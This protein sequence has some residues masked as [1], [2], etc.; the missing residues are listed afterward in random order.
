MTLQHTIEDSNCF[1]ADKIRMIFDGGYGYYWIFPR[2]PEKKEVN[3]GFGTFGIYDY[4]L[5]ELLEEFKKKNNIQ[6]KV[7][8]V[9]GGLLPL[10][11]QRPFK[12]KNILFVGD[13]GVGTFPFSGQ[14]IYRALLSGDIA[15][16]CIAKGITKKYPYMINQ[17]FIKWQVFGK[18]FYH[19]N[20]RFRKINPELVLSSLR[21]FGRFVEIVHIL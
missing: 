20:F 3:V 5:K 2:N 14:G 19:I 6:G 9:L 12:Y 15:G 21:N 16:K 7:N 13:A 10:G 18:I 17:A 4:N 8:Y 1:I 11:L